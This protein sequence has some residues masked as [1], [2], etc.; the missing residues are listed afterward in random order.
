MLPR[1]TENNVA[2]ALTILV[3]TGFFVS[4]VLDILDYVIVKVILFGSTTILFIGVLFYL[5][6]Q[7]TKN[8]PKD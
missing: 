8:R 7:E 3:V 5:Y 4:G 6:K 2:R 1:L